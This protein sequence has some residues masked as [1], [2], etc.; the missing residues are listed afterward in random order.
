MIAVDAIMTDEV[1]TLMCYFS[2][3]HKPTASAMVSVDRCKLEH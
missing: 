1:Y 2:S 3:F